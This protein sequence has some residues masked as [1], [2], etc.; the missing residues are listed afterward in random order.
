MIRGNIKLAAVRKAVIPVIVCVLFLSFVGM[1]LAQTMPAGQ[2]CTIPDYQNDGGS[3]QADAWMLQS[4]GQTVADCLGQTFS[5]YG[6]KTM[7]EMINFVYVDPYATSVSNAQ[8]RFAAAVDAAGFGESIWHTGGYTSYIAGVLYQQQPTSPYGAWADKSFYDSNIHHFRAFGP[9]YYNGAYYTTV[10]TSTES[11]VWYE[12]THVWVSFVTARTALTSDL[13]SQ[14]YDP[15][16][17]QLPNLNLGNQIP[18]SNPTLSTG[19]F[20]GVTVY[21]ESPSSI[22]MN[23]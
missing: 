22:N 14:T 1:A 5:Q 20:D 23:P 13:L 3:F 11:Y 7:Q 17:K 15:G 2:A 21:M 9:Y 10:A 12:F 18:T 8:A 6:N 19:D 16:F 4:D